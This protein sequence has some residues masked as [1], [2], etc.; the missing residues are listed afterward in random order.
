M[1]FLIVKSS[2]N[3]KYAKPECLQ[4][5]RACRLVNQPYL[6]SEQVKLLELMG[7]HI[8]YSGEHKLSEYTSNIKNKYQN[9]YVN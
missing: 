2:N 3:F 6:T 5:E 8:E 4:A 1:K 7:L 9:L